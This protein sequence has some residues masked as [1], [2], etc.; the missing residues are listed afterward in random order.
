VSALTVAFVNASAW[1]ATA[2][3]P[4][5][6]PA[7][8]GDP[9]KITPGILGFAAIFFVALATVFL[10]VDMNRRIRRTRYRG[11]IQERLREEA[12]AESTTGA[13]RKQANTS[14]RAPQGP[15]GS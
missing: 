6:M 7:Y 8:T 15:E 3:T 13:A 11:E 1:L 2:P 5:P 10:I 9:D 4:T 14:P 12:E